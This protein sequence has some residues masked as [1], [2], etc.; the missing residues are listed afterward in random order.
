M[1][2]GLSMAMGG[3][4]YRATQNSEKV[5]K[6]V[7]SML[8]RLETGE[9]Y[10]YVHENV[11][12]VIES[13]GLKQKVN[14]NDIATDRNK[15]NQT[16]LESYMT[17]QKELLAQFNTLKEVKSKYD[18][19]GGSAATGDDKKTTDALQAQA[20][21]LLKSFATLA[22]SAVFQGKD[23][24]TANAG[25]INANNTTN[26]SYALAF[27]EVDTSGIIAAN[28]TAGTGTDFIDGLDGAI[29]SLANNSARA[30]VLYNNVLGA[31]NNV[32]TGIVNASSQRYSSLV[33][34]DDNETSALLSVLSSRMDAISA[35][36]QYGGQYMGNSIQLANL[37]A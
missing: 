24:V 11:A 31:N 18:A 8:N 5:N 15:K 1:E 19:L 14:G 25:A 12:A 33:A 27:E 37:L 16:E 6:A 20:D 9:K 23:L 34:A 7:N 13:T 35:S 10:Q 30:G 28:F 26:G 2:I 32:M 4:F 36:K 21:E 3:S 17:G 29:G 22:K